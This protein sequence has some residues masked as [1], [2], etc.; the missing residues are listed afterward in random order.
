VRHR[1]GLVTS[2]QINVC[3]SP[4]P[5]AGTAVSLF[6]VKGSKLC[7][8]E[9]IMYHESGGRVVHISVRHICISYSTFSLVIR[10]HLYDMTT[11]R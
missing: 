5:S 6:C 4:F 9:G 2:T 3:K 10:L 1:L 7:V 8:H 11:S